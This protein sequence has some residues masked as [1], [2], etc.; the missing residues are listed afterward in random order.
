MRVAAGV[1]MK[2]TTCRGE[3]FGPSVYVHVYS[4]SGDGLQEIFL[5]QV[6]N[7]LGGDWGRTKD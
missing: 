5:G 6:R 3:A 2:S 1:T 4:F 7:F